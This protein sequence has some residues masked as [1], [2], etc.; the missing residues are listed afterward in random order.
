MKLSLGEGMVLC[1]RFL[2]F[3]GECEKML[4]FFPQCVL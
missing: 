3:V 4:A 1:L 2:P